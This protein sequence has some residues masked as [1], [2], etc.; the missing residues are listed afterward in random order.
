LYHGLRPIAEAG[1]LALQEGRQA[2]ALDPT[3]S[4][5]LAVLAAAL[6]TV[7]DLHTSLVYVERALACN[8]N[9]ASAHWINSSNL[10]NLGR[11]LEGR[12]EALM[13]L[14]LNPRDP[15]SAMAASNV[16][17][18]Y[19]VEGNY[20]ATVDSAR[21]YLAE[22]PAHHV[23]RRHLVAALGLLGRHEE[24]EAA[25]REWLAVAPGLID[26][27]VGNRPPYTRPEDHAFVVEGM[28][29]AGWKG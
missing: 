28:R 5:A 20:T 26:M 18:S 13:S 10:T 12:K 8:R 23:P 6:T 2:V 24:A 3:D 4:E 1:K 11:T 15:G 16:T 14:R 21:R 22:Y 7:G 9:S 27:V 17:G 25:L 29:K 19:F